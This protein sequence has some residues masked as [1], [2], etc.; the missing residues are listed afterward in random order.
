[1]SDEHQQRRHPRFEMAISVTLSSIDPESDPR[2]GRP[3]FRSVHE[4]CANLSRGGAFVRTSE[5][6]ER[7]RRL[8]LEFEL[9][10]GH[11]LEALGR[12]AWAQRD[13][14]IDGQLGEEG[15]GIE[16]MGGVSRQWRALDTLLDDRSRESGADHD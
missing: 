15:I 5:T 9:P 3:F 2:S 1:M 6:F 13:L 12:V 4:T 14:E 8:L 11:Q 7:G 10:N 16:F